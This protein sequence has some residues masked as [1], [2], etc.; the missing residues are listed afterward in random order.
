MSV[1]YGGDSI[2]FA[3]SSTIA[4]GWTGFKNRVINGA[5]H[6]DQRYRG[7]ARTGLDLSADPWLSDRFRLGGGTTTFKCTMQNVADAPAGFLRSGKIT[8]TTAETVDSGDVTVLSQIIEGN[9]LADLGWGTQ[10]AVAV[11]LSFWVKASITGQYHISLRSDGAGT[12][13]CYVAPYTI[14][15]ANTWEQKTIVVPGPT[16]GTWG[17]LTQSISTGIRLDWNLGTGTG[18]QTATENS[19]IQADSK[20]CTSNTVQ[21]IANVN[22]TWQ[23]TGVQLERGSVAT[24]FEHR[25]YSIELAL[26]KRYCEVLSYDYDTY[27]GASG[28]ALTSGTAYFAFPFLEKRGS[29]VVNFNGG[30][31]YQGQGLAD[32]G[33]GTNIVA[34]R[35]S[36]TGG[37]FYLSATFSGTN[38]QAVNMRSLAAN[39]Q[40]ITISSEL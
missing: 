15:Q 8:I 1:S 20:F 23:I 26:C 10:N 35:V 16:A 31:V 7:A 6:I 24:S 39:T 9:N 28:F 4:S 40:Y 22:A 37:N 14:N 30:V 32:T 2:T 27:T 13:Y 3:D 18:A 29:V 5:F 36:R 21:L 33:N 25:P 38:G 11:T 17:A 12:N 19:W 34:T